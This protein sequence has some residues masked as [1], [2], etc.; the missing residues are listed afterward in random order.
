[1]RM[2]IS[3]DLPIS[4]N[5]SRFR[6]HFHRQWEALFFLAVEIFLGL[7]VLFLHS[8]LPVNNNSHHLLRVYINFTSLMLNI[9]GY[10]VF[11]L[12]VLV[13]LSLAKR[14][15]LAAARKIGDFLG[16]YYALRMITLL[17]GLNIL[18]FDVQSS[19]FLLITQLLF[20]LPYSLL[21]WGWVYWRLDGISRARGKPLFKL[22]HD[23]VRPAVI[24]YFVASFS[25]VFSA[26]ISVVKG[27]SPGSR[28]L[29]LLH[30][31]MIYDIMVLILSRAVAMI[32]R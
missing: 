21:V 3:S 14:I 23:P 27:T 17:L 6:F 26:S 18:V 2:E 30:G 15:P 10:F 20:F 8:D 32:Q 4:S 5:S 13:F 28:I 25:T 1:M 31:F 22:D 19:R 29:I 24:D 11:P 16:G 12:V 9:G 7:Q